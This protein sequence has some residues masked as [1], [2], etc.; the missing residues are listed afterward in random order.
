[1]LQSPF[2]VYNISYTFCDWFNKL[3]NIPFHQSGGSSHVVNNIHIDVDSLFLRLH[4]ILRS[5][6]PD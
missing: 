3:L 1:M 6:P 5:Y 2:P 4:I